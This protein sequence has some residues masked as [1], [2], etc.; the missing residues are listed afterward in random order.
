M[1]GGYR[2]GHQQPAYP[3]QQPAAP[4]SSYGLDYTAANGGGPELR[5]GSATYSPSL[6]SSSIRICSEPIFRNL[7][8]CEDLSSSISDPDARSEIRCLFDPGSRILDP[9]SQNHIFNSLLTNFWVK[10]TI[11]LSVLAKKF[12]LPVQN[13]IIYN[14]MIFVASKNGRTKK[15]FSPSPFG[16]VVASGIRD[17]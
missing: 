2:N 13:K 6:Q 1:Q 3:H 14:F 12:S 17:G 11:I 5:Q 7:L 15:I 9:G 16:V 8:G 10:G 4:A